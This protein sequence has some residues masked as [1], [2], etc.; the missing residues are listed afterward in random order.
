MANIRDPLTTKNKIVREAEKQFAENGLQAASV[1]V[2][3]E[4]AGINKRMIYHYFGSKEDLYREVLKIN[5]HRIYTIGEKAF[6]NKGDIVA[7]VKQIIREY[8]YF[9]WDNPSYVK[10]MGWEEIA[11]GM[12]AR[13]IMPDSLLMGYAR[14]RE[15]YD[16]GVKKNVLREELDLK[17]LIISINAL[18]F[19]TFAR[20]ELLEV[21]WKDQIDINLEARLEHLY[22][23]ILNGICR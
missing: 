20:R 13:E 16:D 15:L 6:E 1:N 11:G 5:F 3:A 9:L 18:C 4:N 17:Q 22:D 10:I 12:I 14:L 23:L 7:C 8:Y 2:I 19:L 21:L